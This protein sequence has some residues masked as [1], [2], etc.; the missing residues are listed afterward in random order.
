MRYNAAFD[1]TNSR[2][3]T[4]VSLVLQKTDFHASQTFARSSAQG[5]VVLRSCCPTD[6][7]PAG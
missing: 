4:K 2:Y 5:S 6:A 1:I 7:Y 3:D